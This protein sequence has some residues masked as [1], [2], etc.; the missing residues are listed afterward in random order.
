MFV[1]PRLRHNQFAQAAAAGLLGRVA[2]H[3]RERRIGVQNVI[4]VF[5]GNGLGN[6]G[7]HIFH[8]PRLGR[9]LPSSGMGHDHG[10]AQLRI[11]NAVGAFNRQQLAALG[12]HGRVKRAALPRARQQRLRLG[13]AGNSP[14]NTSSTG[15]STHS[16]SVSPSICRASALANTI[17][18]ARSRKTRTGRRVQ[19]LPLL[20]GSRSFPEDSMPWPPEEPSAIRP[21]WVSVPPGSRLFGAAR[22]HMNDLCR[23]RDRTTIPKIGQGVQPK[24][25]CLS[26]QDELLTAARGCNLAKDALR[27]T[28]APLRSE[29]NHPRLQACH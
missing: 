17:L 8:Q 27:R 22:C 2:K 5:D 20:V 9:A 3:L 28:F 10:L 21:H 16:P 4:A 11:E 13:R 26:D 29:L 25:T 23:A 6:T 14:H 18:P 12:R 15:R 24:S 19:N 1:Q 7:Q